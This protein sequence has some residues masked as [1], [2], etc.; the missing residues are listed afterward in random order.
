MYYIDLTG[1]TA[2]VALLSPVEGLLHACLELLFVTYDWVLCHLLDRII[3]F[4]LHE[5]A[6]LC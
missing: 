2:N 4:V 6:T 3:R 1:H 5:A